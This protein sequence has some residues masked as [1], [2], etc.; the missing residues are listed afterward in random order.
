M[1]TNSAPDRRIHEDEWMKIDFLSSSISFPL[2]LFVLAPFKRA[3]ITIWMVEQRNFFIYRFYYTVQCIVYT[4]IHN[5]HA[6]SQLKFAAL[7]N[8]CALCTESSNSFIFGPCQMNWG[9]KWNIEMVIVLCKIEIGNEF[10]WKIAMNNN[11]FGMCE[12]DCSGISTPL[13]LWRWFVSIVHC[14]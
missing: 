3:C 10:C 8:C 6:L 11:F 14:W 9:M 1:Q 13:V 7:I 4:S 5:I 2:P 12:W